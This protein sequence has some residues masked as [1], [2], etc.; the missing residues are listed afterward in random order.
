MRR[1]LVLVRRRA[2]LYRVVSLAPQSARVVIGTPI[3]T[4]P[5]KKSC[6]G[7]ALNFETRK[8]FYPMS[9]TPLPS[10]DHYVGEK[11]VH[12]ITGATYEIIKIGDPADCGVPPEFVADAR[13]GCQIYFDGFT[14]HNGLLVK[15]IAS[16]EKQVAMLNTIRDI[17][18]KS[19]AYWLDTRPIKRTVSSFSRRGA[20]LRDAD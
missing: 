17:P 5:K 1:P 11:F 16:N 18:K 12:P 8:V 4:E 13:D 10:V 6:P 19:V 9:S 15:K 20:S 2:D 7:P 14:F 3:T